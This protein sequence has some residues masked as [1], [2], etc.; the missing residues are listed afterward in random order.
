MV[1]EHERVHAEDALVRIQQRVLRVLDAEDLEHGQQR[2]VLGEAHPVH[3]ARD[4][5]HLEDGVVIRL[6]VDDFGEV[7]LDE[8]RR[9][10]RFDVRGG[11]SACFRRLVRSYCFGTGRD[12]VVRGQLRQLI[13]LLV[14]E[15]LTGHEH[16]IL[17]LRLL[18]LIRRRVSARGCLG[19]A[20]DDRSI[21][22]RFRRLCGLSLFCVFF[23]DE[24]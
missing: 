19:R 9:I 11:I 13:G 15:L 3:P 16:T 2:V 18:I 21:L 8:G 6:D 24:I 12:L 14:F 4:D 20:L 23:I 1:G 5:G 22:R 7:V 10:I 17:T